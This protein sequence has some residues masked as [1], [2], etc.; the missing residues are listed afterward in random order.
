MP[1]TAAEAHSWYPA[2]V[3][4]CDISNLIIIIGLCVKE[5]CGGVC[6]YDIERCTGITRHVA[7]NTH[8]QRQMYS[9]TNTH[10]HIMT[11]KL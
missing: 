4:L 10:A 3:K 7:G 6:A 11:H 9:Q 2:A 5:V 8:R 1:F